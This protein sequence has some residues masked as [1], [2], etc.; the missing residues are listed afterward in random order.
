MGTVPE[1]VRKDPIGRYSN[2]AVT[3]HWL[4]AL[5][6]LTQVVLGF[7]FAEFMENGPERSYVFAWH[8]TLGA[9]I[10]ILALIRLAYRLKNPPPPFPPQ[11]PRWRQVFPS[12]RPR[13]FYF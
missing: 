6:V 12:F 5:L 10:F 3:L 2:V 7:A 1:A 4:T 11:L 9:L 8:K 13:D